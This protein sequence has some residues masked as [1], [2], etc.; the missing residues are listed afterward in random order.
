MKR[1]LG[2]ASIALVSFVILSWV[3][4]CSA[5]QETGPL[6]AE[7]RFELGMKK[8]NDEDYLDAIE[9][10]RIVALQYQGSA[11]AD[12]AQFY[13]GESR[14]RRE[15]YILAAYE[16]EVLTRTMPTSEYISKA[17]FKRALCYYNLSPKSYLD[18]EYTKRAIDEFQSFIEYHPT[19]SLVSHAEAKIMELNTKLAKKEFENGTNYMTMEYYKAAIISFDHILE[20]YYDTP[21]AERAQLK[22]AEAL[23]LRNKLVEAKREIEKFFTKYPSSSFKADAEKLRQDI[24]DKS[25]Q[26]NNN[27]KDKPSGDQTTQRMN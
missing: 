19:D 5:S 17:R 9:D 3:A 26:K 6:S 14:F 8:F 11:L 25:A 16:Y 27:I 10:F 7:K 1:N 4:G 12:D 13:L 18:Q 2:I 22:K 21:Y 24:L 20:K 23:Y 15:E